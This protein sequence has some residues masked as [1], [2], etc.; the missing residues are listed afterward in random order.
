MS[1]NVDPDI[2]PTNTPPLPE[3]S[4]PKL[5]NCVPSSLPEGDLTG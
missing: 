2:Y 5:E 4:P 1:E 3:S